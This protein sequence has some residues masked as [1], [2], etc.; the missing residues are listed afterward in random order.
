MVIIA[1]ILLVF[2]F[3]WVG[4]DYKY[5]QHIL[6][7]QAREAFALSLSLVGEMK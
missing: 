6:N 5:K 3:H 7:L 4:S 2:H 1:W